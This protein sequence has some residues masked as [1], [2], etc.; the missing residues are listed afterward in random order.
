MRSR[1]AGWASLALLLGCKGPAESAS[2]AD[3]QH[4]EATASSKEQVFWTW[5]VENEQRLRTAIKADARSVV[6]SDS[7]NAELDRIHPSLLFELAETADGKHELIISADGD[8]NAFPAVEALVRTAP[9]LEHWHF[10]AFRQPSSDL[11]F[12]L[13]MGDVVLSPQTV[14]Y[15]ST[16]DGDR[17]AITIYLPGELSNGDPGKLASF[18]LLDH[19]LGEYDVE[20]QL[21]AIDWAVLPSEP[22][23]LAPL[24]K[25]REEVAERKR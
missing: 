24:T 9:T 23:D 2:E 4:E 16:T 18:L 11:D 22:G 10:T 14:L 17:L 25:L 15:R 3:S 7:M 19:I 6:E 13:A 20:T 21:G 8:R 1:L 12:E 5:F